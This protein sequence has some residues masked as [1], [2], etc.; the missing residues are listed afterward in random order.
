MGIGSSILFPVAGGVMARLT[1]TLSGGIGV[2]IAANL[3]VRVLD[4]RVEEFDLPDCLVSCRGDMLL[5][6][7][8]IDKAEGVAG[9]RIKFK[10][11]RVSVSGVDQ[12]WIKDTVDNY[13]AGGAVS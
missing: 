12:V 1:D 2:D 3:Y 10:G 7:L 6:E 4:V 11:Y 8:A 13:G 5:D 9:G